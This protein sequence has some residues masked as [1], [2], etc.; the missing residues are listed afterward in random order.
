GDASTPAAVYYN[1]AGMNQIKTTTFTAGDIAIAPQASFKSAA[2][3]NHYTNDRKI[4]NI[5]DFYAVTPINK[6]LSLGVGAGSYWG[7][8][9]KWGG[10]SPLRYATTA[11]T[12]VVQ[13]YMLA[14]SYKVTDQWTVAVSLDNDWAVGNQTQKV[15]LSTYSLP[16][17]TVQIKQNS[18]AWGYRIATMFRINDKNQIGLMYR[19]RIDHR[20]SGKAYADG[21]S[22]LLTSNSYETKVTDKETFP[23][24]VVI[25]YDFKPTKKW[26]I[27]FDL[28]WFDWSQLQ[29]V[30]L[31]FPNETNAQNKTVLAGFTPISYKWHSTWSEA[32]GTE[33]AVTDKFRVRAGYYH[34]TSVGPNATFTPEI[35]D[36]NSH[37]I[38]TGFGYDIN[39]HLTLDISYGIAFYEPR[40]VYGN[41]ALSGPNGAGINGD[42]REITNFGAAS[43]TYKF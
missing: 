8:G 11:A 36:M 31:N 29:Q 13:D 4:N 33:Y 28:E 20:F 42:Y 38:T 22:P 15:N 14:A 23:Q 12:L 39:R 27:N 30:N 10:D 9:D 2:T 37:G 17:G 18:D 6:K 3:G 19:S 21:M 43:L 16:D 41:T 32:I 7:L 35:P 5:P 24:S 25:G 26:K 1:P 34:H 40:T